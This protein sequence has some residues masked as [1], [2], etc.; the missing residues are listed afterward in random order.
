MSSS[1]QFRYTGLSNR[2]IVPH[3]V[4]KDLTPA[5]K[6]LNPIIAEEVDQCFREELPPGDLS[7]LTP[8]N[9]NYTLLRIVAVVSGRIFI[10]PEL[11][12]TPEYVDMAMNYTMDIVNAREAVTRLPKGER[13]LKASSLTE[14]K[15]LRERE[16]KAWE[17]L[18]PIIEARLRAVEDPDY[19]KPDDLLQWILDSPAELTQQDIAEMQLALTFA[20]IHTTTMTVTS[21]FY[22]LAARPELVP[23]LREEIRSALRV[24]GTFTSAA[25]LDMKKMDSFFSENARYYPLA[26]T[27]FGRKV[28]QDFTLS[29]GQVI[30]AGVTIE[31]ASHPMA[32]DP[33]VV[34]DPDSFDM[35]RSYKLRQAAG[36]A[37]SGGGG[38]GGANQ[39]VTA[40]P[41][42][43]MWGYGRHACPGRYFAANE[44]K[45]IVSRAILDYEF[46]NVDGHEGRYPN[47][48]FGLQS[49]PDP[50]KQLLFK[51]RDV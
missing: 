31:V 40:S 19:R 32:F 47:M 35:L 49:I 16:K 28:L 1:M 29:T 14:V 30:P 41:S 25:L 9:I 39:F 15:T 2:P 4:K 44:A 22:T 13:H 10:G 42:N 6:R 17:I 45:M 38:G 43:L 23:E 36:A 34:A 20:A 3:I 18:K 24:H 51:R 46:R 26:F 5:L 11:F 33:E 27:S 12:R 48:D 21:A 7:T 37:E 8:V 50:T